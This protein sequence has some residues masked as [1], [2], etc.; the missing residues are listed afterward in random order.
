MKTSFVKNGML[1]CLGILLVFTSCSKDEDTEVGTD[2]ATAAITA[3]QSKQTAEAEMSTDEVFNII[4]LAYAE[5]EEGA[6]RNQ[7]YFPDCVTITISSENGVVFVTLDFGAGCE[8]QNGAYVSGKINFTYGPPVAGT[9]TVTYTLED[10]THNNR[11]VEGSGSL[12]RER[13]ND[14]GNPQHTVNHELVITWP[15]GVV[16]QA[17]GTRVAEWIEGVGSGTWMDN[18]FSVTGNRDIEFNTGFSH[19][20][21]VTEALRKE[22]TCPHFVSGAVEITRN[23]GMGTLDFGE[24]DCDNLAVLTVNGQ[25][26]IIILD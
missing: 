4:E 7:S 18:V 17:D 26:I 23:N 13:T 5:N 2:D 20:A 9:V 24:G 6:G 8:L 14:N 3:E 15:N 10:F 25:E 16:A 1:A 22:V 12:F 21:I 19:Y 11:A